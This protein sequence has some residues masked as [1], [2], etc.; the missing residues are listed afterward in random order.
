MNQKW[1]H[2]CLNID[3]LTTSLRFFQLEYRTDLHVF[4][5]SSNHYSNFIG[6]VTMRVRINTIQNELRENKMKQ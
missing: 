2:W 6:S 3:S 1:P 4:Y 5:L